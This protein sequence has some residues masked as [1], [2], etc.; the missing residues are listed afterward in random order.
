[1]FTVFPRSWFNTSVVSQCLGAHSRMRPNFLLTLKLYLAQY[2]M[3]VMAIMTIMLLAIGAWLMRD[4]ERYHYHAQ[5]LT[6]GDAF[7]MVT[8][9]F[10]TIGYGD[11]Y[12]Y[13]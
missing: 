11:V 5:Q 4:C 8:I 3:L 13:R 2:S 12:P 10:L 7:W 9:T 6:Y 1:M